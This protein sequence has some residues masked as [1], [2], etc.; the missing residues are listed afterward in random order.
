M[1][2][3]PLHPV[4]GHHPGRS[5]AFDLLAAWLHPLAVGAGL[6]VRFV[7]LSVLACLLFSAPVSFREV[8][9]ASHRP[10]PGH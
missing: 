10:S 7:A 1:H 4:T 9:D 2:I 6:A 8:P 3:H 5:A